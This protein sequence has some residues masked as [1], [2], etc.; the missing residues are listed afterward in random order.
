MEYLRGTGSPVLAEWVGGPNGDDP[1][2]CAVL[3]LKAMTGSELLPLSDYEA[4]LVCLPSCC[5]FPFSLTQ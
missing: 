4:L 5:L 1:V 2:G 3:L